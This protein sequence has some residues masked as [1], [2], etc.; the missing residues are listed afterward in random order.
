MLKRH[1]TLSVVCSLIGLHPLVAQRG[2]APVRRVVFGRPSG[3]P[4][5]NASVSIAGG[6]FAMNTDPSGRFEFDSVPPGT[7]VI[8]ARHAL[9]DSIG[10]PGLS[11]KALTSEDGGRGDI[12][13]SVPSFA[14]M[15]RVACGDRRPPRD[16]GIVY[17][18]IRDA[19]SSRP[20]PAA[21]VGG[22]GCD[23]GF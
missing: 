9:L 7:F 3:K 5:G 10:L 15:W 6:R 14:S 12:N 22:S 11:T 8:T 2:L 23:F 17:G 20:I 16:S 4:L 21:P 13:L 18:T 19:E 1:L